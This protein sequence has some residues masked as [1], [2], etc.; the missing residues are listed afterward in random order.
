MLAGKVAVVTGAASGIGRA[1]GLALA[2]A[3]AAVVVSDLPDSPMA[4][5]VAEIEAVD[6][7]AVAWATD[8]TDA[9][10]C[11]RLMA[12]AVDVFGTLDVLFANAG[13]ALTGRDGFAPDI[14]PADWDRVIAVNLNG[15]FYCCRAAIPRMADSGG[16]AIVNSASS[17]ATLPLGGFDAYAASKFGVAGLTKSLAVGCGSLG[18][19]VN[20]IGPGYVDTPMNALIFG[21]DDVKDAF[22]LG[23]ATGLQTPEEIADLV[24]FLASDAS[25]SLTGALLTCDRGWTAFKQPDLRRRFQP[26]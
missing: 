19:R 15:V 16:G 22:D 9:A 25:R 5:V 14:D 21:I 8:V 23:H 11:E 12:H 26:S 18:I 7:R 4:E 24:V 10:A 20:A 13:V 3:G 1:S 17:M 6:G 2:R